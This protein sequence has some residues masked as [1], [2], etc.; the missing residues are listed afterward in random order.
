MNFE[1]FQKLAV[2]TAKP[3]PFHENVRHVTFGLCG[4]A[5]EFADA[6][7]K[8]DIYGQNLDVHNAIEE[9]A[10]V[11]WYVALGAEAFD[12][13]LEEIAQTVINK[14]SKRYP[15]KYTDELAQRR[16]DKQSIDDASEAEWDRAAQSRVKSQGQE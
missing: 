9:L 7:K 12:V 16:L 8:W 3:L 5:G 1:E 2:R 15:E 13:P 14:L 6:I 10:D 4:E 11:L